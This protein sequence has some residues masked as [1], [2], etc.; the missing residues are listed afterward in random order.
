[1]KM[2]LGSGKGRPLPGLLRAG[3]RGP[4]CLEAQFT[5]PFGGFGARRLC[6]LSPFLFSEKLSCRFGRAPSP[7]PNNLHSENPQGRQMQ[8][9]P[10]SVCAEAEIPPPG[11]L[12]ILP[13]ASFNGCVCSRN[14]GE[15]PEAEKARGRPARG[16]R[17]QWA[18][19]P[20]R[21]PHCRDQF[22]LKLRD[23]FF[24]TVGLSGCV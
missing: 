13:Q 4:A 21:R 22:T 8:R 5:G 2:P 14:F 19:I 9:K 17:P 12:F 23:V 20:G 1:M 24:P 6:E 11:S 16:G 10:C 18:F 15:S 3:W 7:G